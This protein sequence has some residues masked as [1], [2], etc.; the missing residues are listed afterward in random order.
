MTWG[1]RTTGGGLPIGQVAAGEL[2]RFV[3]AF[4]LP[5]LPKC[6]F[7]RKNAGAKR[8]SSRKMP[9]CDVT[10]HRRGRFRLGPAGNVVFT[11]DGNV[12]GAGTLDGSGTATF[13]V[14][15]DPG[16]S[17]QVVGGSGTN[18]LDYTGYIGNVVADLQ[19]G[20]ATGFSSIANIQNVT[21]ASGGV[22]QGLYNLLIGN[23]GNVLTGGT[24][25][26]NILVVGGSASTLIGGDQDDLLIAGTTSYD[27]DPTLATWLE[28]AAYWAGTDDFATRVANLTS[29]NGVPLLDASVVTGNGGG[30]TLTGPGELALIYTDGSDTISGLDPS[31]QQ[32][33][34]TP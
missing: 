16:S 13:T 8:A 27:T 21:G 10:N 33:A 9:P 24:G 11:E 2:V 12:I 25:R 29:G 26:R 6:G 19:T 34:I 4:D 22:A 23:G 20:V 31:S 5:S 32:V 14:V 30:N 15:L 17:M 7:P 3:T 28:I 1:E 18:T